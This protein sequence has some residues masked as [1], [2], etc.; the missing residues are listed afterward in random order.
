MCICHLFTVIAT[1]EN[2]EF[3]DG[4]PI[5]K[6]ERIQ[7]IQ[8]LEK[9]RPIILKQELEY[10]E[11]R[12]DEKLSNLIEVR[13]KAKAY[14]DPNLDLDTKRRNFYESQSKHNPEFRKEN[15]RFRQYLQVI[16][17][18]SF[19]EALILASVNPQYGKRLFIDSPKKYMFRT[20]CVQILF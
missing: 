2:I 20:C 3:L 11:K 10:L 17:G 8:N 4:A 13:D 18:K 5:E 6:S 16:T 7:A 12:Q 9:I 15:Q 1:L 14:D 19:S